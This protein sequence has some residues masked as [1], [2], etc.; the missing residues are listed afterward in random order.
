MSK[1]SLHVP[2]PTK[3][4]TPM[5]KRSSFPSPPIAE[6]LVMEEPTV[7]MPEGWFDQ[8]HPKEG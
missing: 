3:R 5:A 6:R 2:R 8:F 4:D 7:K 1:T